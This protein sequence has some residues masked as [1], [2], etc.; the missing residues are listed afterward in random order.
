M[1]YPRHEAPNELLFVSVWRVH[2]L[3]FAKSV[4]ESLLNREVWS[5]EGVD[6]KNRNE[7]FMSCF[8][9]C[10]F[11]I[12]RA[13]ETLHELRP[14]F[15]HPVDIVIGKGKEV[16]EEF[17]ALVKNTIHTRDILD[18][19]LTPHRQ[20]ERKLT[21]NEDFTFLSLCEKRKY[22]SIQWFIKYFHQVVRVEETNL[23]R[24][25]GV[26]VP[27]YTNIVQF[28]PSNTKIDWRERLRQALSEE[29]HLPLSN[30]ANIRRVEV[31]AEAARQT[32][33]DWIDKC[34]T[35]SI[36][37]RAFVSIVLYMAAKA[38]LDKAKELQSRRK[39][40]PS[41]IVTRLLASSKEHEHTL[42]TIASF[43]NKN[44]TMLTP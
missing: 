18:D 23:D 9:K 42:K 29:L 19:V 26:R 40:P 15:K 6:E 20:S 8:D 33:E 25:V 11:A 30:E 37:M 28:K 44:I 27:F 5:A 1:S 4:D 31:F 16:R 36:Q 43:V 10:R 24:E 17:A 21:D 38:R 13:W 2:V 39:K 12:E 34:Q 3:E 7:W 22:E 32:I 14:V 35:E 41:W